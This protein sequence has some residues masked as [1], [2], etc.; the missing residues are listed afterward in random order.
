MQ[1]F[2]EPIDDYSLAKH[3]QDLEI[4]ATP[5]LQFLLK[6]RLDGGFVK[7]AITNKKKVSL[8]TDRLIDERKSPAF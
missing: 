7:K 8:R 3:W 2:D 4:F 5:Y 1:L 6:N